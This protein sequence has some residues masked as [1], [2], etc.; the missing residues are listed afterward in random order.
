MPVQETVRVF[1]YPL[2]TTASS[3]QDLE[4]HAGAARWAYNFAHAKLLAQWRAFDA[5]KLSAAEALSGLDTEAIVDQLSKAERRQLFATARQAV[6]RENT[7]LTA[8][9]KVLDEHRRRVLH[10]GKPHLDPGDE[11][12]G[13]ASGMARRL[14]QRRHE[15]AALQ[16]ADP[17]GY[18]A[19]K[20]REL[21]SVRPRVTELKTTLAAQG[22]YR[23]GAFDIQNFWTGARDLPR[24]E[25]GSPWWR[26]VAQRVFA[27]GFDRADTAWKNWMKSASGARKGPRM[28]MPRFKKKGKARDSFALPNAARNIIFLDTARRLRVAGVGTYRLAQSAKPL[29]RMITKDQAEITSVTITRGGHRWYA[30]LVCTVQQNIPARPTQ[31][32]R[33]AGLIAADLGSQPLAVLSAPLDPADSTSST[34]PSM[35]PLHADWDRLT[36]AQRK[37][38][39]T[40]RGSKRRRRAAR[41][42]GKLH[43]VIA[44]R[45]ASFLHGVSKRLAVGAQHIAIENLD[46]LGLTASAK[47]TVEEPG[48]DVKVTSQFNRHLLD[49]GLGEL[50]RQ[51]AYKTPWYGSTLIVLDK[52]EPTASKCSKC[53][54]RNPSSKPSDKRFTCRHC[55][56]DVSRRDNS[57]HSIYKAARKQLTTSVAPGRGDTQNAL[58]GGDQPTTGNGGGPPPLKR[59]PP[60]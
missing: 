50:R 15:L 54:E 27:C 16:E 47:G 52:G 24:T 36:R 4:R 30:S 7:T 39:R 5:R 40:K 6:T 18:A 21:E 14:Y 55:G 58:R 42:V 48:T 56:L 43:H 20:K 29:L 51:L 59:P 57:V 31:R 33:A 34:V 28:G 60:P 1:R 8:D 32:Q 44:E 26:E 17:A 2:V 25:G 23:P 35:K 3:E 9:L 46:L 41:R 22:A 13:D 19:A 10:K 11:P 12:G 38:S 37:L 49:S 53:S 45:R